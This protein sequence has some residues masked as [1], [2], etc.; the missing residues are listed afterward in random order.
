VNE[1]K[2]SLYPYFLILLAL[3]V[4]SCKT[5]PG[6]VLHDPGIGSTGVTTGIDGIATEQTDI[7]VTSNNI[8]HDGEQVR[9][10]LDEIERAIRDGKDFSAILDEII[11]SIRSRPIPDNLGI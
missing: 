7:A 11:R 5:I 1:R 6:T 8:A 9:I 4:S 3:F 2:K 10:G